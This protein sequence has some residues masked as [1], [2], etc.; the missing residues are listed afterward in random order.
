MNIK[1][2]LMATL[3]SILLICTTFGALI[4]KS[5]IE[6]L[7]NINT[8]DIDVQKYI[9]LTD[10]LSLSKIQVSWKHVASI[11]ATMNNNKFNH[12]DDN[13]IKEIGKLFIINNNGTYTLSNF[14][15]VMNELDFTNKQKE[16][17]HK[18]LSDLE[19]YG[20]KPERLDINEKYV[21]FI[22]SIKDA[23][24]ENYKKYNILPSITI[25]QAILESSW[26]ESKL[27]QDHNNL[28]GIKAH[29]YWKGDTVSVKT[30]EHFNT[31]IVDSFR[32]YETRGESIKD[33]AQFLI[34]NPRYSDVFSKKTYKEQAQALQEAGYSTASDEDGNL[35]Y[36]EK[37]IQL[38]QQY[39]LQVIDNQAQ[40]QK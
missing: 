38:I 2:I 26:G 21:P 16:R 34:E 4:I 31:E 8:S 23:A 9:D 27:T 19:Y 10:E 22:N 3:I 32:S 36:A 7:K 5:R 37:L 30:K 13:E 6:F 33:H 1:K 39:N 12:V 11:I 20:L 24:I 35:I 40:G 28:F 15:T 25:A 17:A 18:Y 29:S 14:D